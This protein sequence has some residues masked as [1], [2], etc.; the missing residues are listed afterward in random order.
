MAL[1][2]QLVIDLLS[3]KRMD[4]IPPAA[5]IIEIGAQQLSNSFFEP[6]TELVEIFELFEQQYDLKKL[7]RS[8][9]VLNASGFAFL[10]DDAPSSRSFWEALGFNYASI[11]YDGHRNSTPLDLNRDQVPKVMKSKFDLVINSGTTEHIANQDHAFKVIHDLVKPGGL[12]IHDVPAG[13]MVTHGVIG[14][15]MQFFFMLC[16][17][18]GYRVIDLGLV[19][20]GRMTIHPDI[21]VSN[22]AFS[23][24]PSHKDNRYALPLDPKLEVPVFMI[25]AVLQKTNDAQFVTP[26]DI[27]ENINTRT[28]GGKTVSSVATQLAKAKSKGR[29]ALRPLKNRMYG[30]AKAIKSRLIG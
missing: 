23:H 12:M 4:M 2:P 16:R 18:N 21:I 27:P 15:N 19:Y 7:R 20:C 29:D 13:G 1:G 6:E 22:A 10:N 26:L 8:N 14:Y 30:F 25:R 17:D 3:L 9:T 5:E 11:D 24:L 28:R